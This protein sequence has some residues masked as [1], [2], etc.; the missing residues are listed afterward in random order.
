MTQQ[1]INMLNNIMHSST[2]EGSSRAEGTAV[3]T[4]APSDTML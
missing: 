4:E 1:D 3:P 2:D